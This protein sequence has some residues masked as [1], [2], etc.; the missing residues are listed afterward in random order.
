MTPSGGKIGGFRPA[1]QNRPFLGFP[2]KTRFPG[3]GTKTLEGLRRVQASVQK[4]ANLYST[5]WRLF[6]P[7]LDPPRPTPPGRHSG[8]FPTFFRG[9]ATPPTPPGTPPPGPLFGSDLGQSGNRPMASWM[10]ASF[11]PP[12]YLYS[13]LYYFYMILIRTR[14]H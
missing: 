2:L 9:L 5:K 10:R 12:N 13:I 11:A 8:G 7:H 1:P 3:P 6:R 14:K 4:P